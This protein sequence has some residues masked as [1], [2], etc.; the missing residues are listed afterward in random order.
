MNRIKLCCLFGGESS[1]YEVSLRTAAAM[2]SNIDETR[3]EIYKVG[4]TKSGNWY[5]YDGTLADI[6]N[7]SWCADESKMAPAFLSPSKNDGALCIL[8]PADGSYRKQPIDVI[9]PAVHGTNCED[10][11]LQ[12][13]MQLTGIPFVGSDCL[14][15]AVCM[16]KATTKSVLTPYGIP[17]AK[18]VFA[19]AADLNERYDAL[20]QEVASL[21]YPVFV[22]PSSAGSSVGVS[23]VKA[24]ED[25]RAA[26]EEA[27]QYDQKV[28]IE[29]FIKGREVEVAV[30]GNETPVASVCGEIDPGAEFYD[31]ESKYLADTAS[32]FIPARLDDSLSDTIRAGACEIY[33]RLGCR[34]LSRVDFFVK[35]DGSFVFNEI[36][37]LPGFTS[38]SMYPKLFMAG[39]MTYAEVINSLISLALEKK[40]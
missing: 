23:K 8:S 11:V 39:G 34:G 6:E 12:G 35:D 29:E 4:I 24:P 30:M 22:K 32:Y 33:R 31:Y 19:S 21:G 18:A 10:G 3:Y 17:Q 25:L 38:I 13:L 16:D 7:G 1:E 15:S 40:D 28:L 37:T 26:L 20:T 2:L 36:N 14:A 27:L 9:L 5:Y